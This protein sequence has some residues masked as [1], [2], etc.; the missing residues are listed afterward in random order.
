VKPTSNARSPFPWFGGKQRLADTIVGLF[1]PHDC[2]VEVFGG[3]GSVLFTKAPATL[4]VY[5]DRDDGLVNFFRMLRERP[6]ELVPLLELTPYSRSEWARARATW[7]SI[8]DD[9]ER[10]RAFYVVVSQSFGGFVSKRGRGWGG[11]RLGRMHL[12][13]AA[14]TANRVDHVWPFVERMRQV[15]IE[16]LDWRECLE[17]YDH[18]TALFYLDPPYVPATRRAG[19][20]RHELT[21]EEHKELVAR[22]CDLKGVVVV[23]GYEHEVYA[24]LVTDAGFERYEFNV[25]STVA[26]REVQTKRD[27]R[28]EVVWT[29]PGAARLSL[30]HDGAATA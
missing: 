26:Q 20:Y 16:C 22:V 10:A 27:R 17:R 3:G 21:V 13:R 4:D 9:L 6:K 30:F 18:E 2:Y 29:R 11:E 15:Q 23:S 24:P 19:G 25:W 28:T 1:P 7:A 5:N 12:S 8:E 14:S